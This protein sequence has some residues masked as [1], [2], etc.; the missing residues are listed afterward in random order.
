MLCKRALSD[1]A[2]GDDGKEFPA[3]D[4]D[5]LVGY[6]D[7]TIE[8]TDSFLLPLE[9]N[10]DQILNEENILDRLDAYRRAYNKLVEKEEDKEQFKVILNVLMNLYDASKPEIFEKDWQNE[11]FAPLTYLYGLL[12]N[13]IDDEKV[14]KARLRMSQLLDTSVTSQAANDDPSGKFA[15]HGTKIIDLSK[16]DV[17]EIRAEIKT[18]EYKAIEIDDLK[19]FIEDTLKKMLNRNCTRI[20]FSQRYKGIIDRYNAGGSENE[21]YYEQLLQLIEELKKE[22]SRAEIEGLSEEEKRYVCSEEHKVYSLGFP[23]RVQSDAYT[24]RL[25]IKKLKQDI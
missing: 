6:I 22:E 12:H 16:I 3:K 15:I 1:Y 7:A 21:D 8:E 14:N 4:I 20:K 25:L 5:A 23:S 19:A 18:A 10:I 9:I 17:D 13:T 11:K 24:N 2:T